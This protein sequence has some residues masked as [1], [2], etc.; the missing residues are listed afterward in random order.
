MESGS[1]TRSFIGD[2]PVTRL[3]LAMVGFIRIIQVANDQIGRLWYLVFLG[4]A[5]RQMGRL[6]YRRPASGSFR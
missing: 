4:R 3:V 5:L 2:K 6:A 1:I